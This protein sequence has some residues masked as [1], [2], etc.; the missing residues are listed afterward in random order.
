MVLFFKNRSVDFFM[1][2]VN[3]FVMKVEVKRV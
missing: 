3:E 2:D 1:D